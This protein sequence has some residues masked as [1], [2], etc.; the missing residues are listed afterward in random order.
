MCMCMVCVYV[1]VCVAGVCACGSARLTLGV[2]LDCSSTVFIETEM[3]QLKLRGFSVSIL[4]GSKIGSSCYTESSLTAGCLPSPRHI[5]LLALELLTLALSPVKLQ[6]P[7]M[8]LLGIN[9]SVHLRVH[10]RG[11][12]SGG[13]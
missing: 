3:S 7:G 9:S 10:S 6:A 13:A 2:F 12:V 8:L 4:G 1:Y 11:G 5:T